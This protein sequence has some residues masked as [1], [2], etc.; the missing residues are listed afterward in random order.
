MILIITAF[1]IGFIM[2][3][4]WAL[5]VDAVTTKRPLLAANMSVL[6]YICT[7][8]ST[9]LI[10]EKY[11]IAVIAYGTGGW[12][13]TYFLVKLKGKNANPKLH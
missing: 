7:I 1:I 8:I 4:I 5:C 6:L 13:G 9:V 3:F 10:I 2:D 12:F 11:F